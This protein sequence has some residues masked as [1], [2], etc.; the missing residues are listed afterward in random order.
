MPWAVGVRGWRAIRVAA[1]LAAAIV[2]PVQAQQL[3]FAVCSV[4]LDFAPAAMTDGDFN[5]DGVPDLAIVNATANRVAVRLSNRALFQA[6]DCLGA[7]AQGRVYEVGTAPTGIASGDFDQNRTIDVV[8]ATQAGVSLLR[9][10]GTGTFTVEAPLSA[11]SDPQEVLVANVDGDGFADIVV[12]NGAG[13]AVTILYGLAGGGFAAPVSRAVGGAVTAVA[14][15]DFN[16]DSFLDL[17]VATDFGQLVVLIQDHDAPRTFTNLAPL[18]VGVKPTALG[19]GDFNRDGKPD[20]A[21]TSGGAEGMVT[22]WLD[23]LPGSTNPPFVVSDEEPTGSTPSALGIDQL[24]RDFPSYVVVAN[25]ND[26]DLPFFASSDDG[27]LVPTPGDCRDA[28]AGVCQVGDGAIAL[29]LGDLDG[30][31]KSDVVTANQSDAPSLS[32][33]LSS[34]PPYTP[35]PTPTATSTQTPTSTVTPTPTETATETPTATA[36]VTPTLTQTAGPTRTFT[37]TPTPTAVCVSGVCL[38]GPG[39]DVAGQNN[40]ESGLAGMLWLVLPVLA[41]AALRRRKG[42][43]E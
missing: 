8:V 1:L 40:R 3:G 18:D 9:N 34:E 4:N 17:A 21:V 22:I 41:L 39:C 24:N 14:V 26:R 20:I 31:G 42:W 7:I 29:V 19:I 23:R 25:Q 32:I 11:G 28:A 33:L 5:R 2:R 16:D 27:G 12:G 37:I 6:G 15:A 43:D 36:T 13:N 35:T 38:Q 10:D 30:D